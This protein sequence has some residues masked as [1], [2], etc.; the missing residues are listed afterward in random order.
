MTSPH[1]GA[2]CALHLSMHI[3]FGW[4]DPSELHFVRT[5]AIDWRR[6]DALFFEA[7]QRRSCPALI[8]ETLIIVHAQ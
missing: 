1:V 3:C 7:C 5:I 8:G 2:L 4:T 6:T